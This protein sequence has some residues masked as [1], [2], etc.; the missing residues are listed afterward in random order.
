MILETQ[1]KFLNFFIRQNYWTTYKQETDITDLVTKDAS[2]N[3]NKYKKNSLIT[4]FVVI[5][6]WVQVVIRMYD[7][8]THFSLICNLDT[9][10]VAK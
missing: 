1:T 6:E 7:S 9:Q 3:K 5:V 2:I 10:S 4:K 8:S